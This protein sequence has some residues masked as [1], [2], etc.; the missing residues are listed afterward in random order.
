MGLLEFRIQDVS[1]IFRDVTKRIDNKC[2]AF[3]LLARHSLGDGG[4]IFYSVGDRARPCAIKKPLD[5]VPN[6]RIMGTLKEVCYG[7]DPLKYQLG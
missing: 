3:G 7:K 1:F 4:C 6:W 5:N 2:F